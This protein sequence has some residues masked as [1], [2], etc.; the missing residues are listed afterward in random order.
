VRNAADDESVVKSSRSSALLEKQVENSGSS[1][2]KV[3]SHTATAKMATEL[4]NDTTKNGTDREA[5]E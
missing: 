5:G 1:F 4:T 2:S 3:G